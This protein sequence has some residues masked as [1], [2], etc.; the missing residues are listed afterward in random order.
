MSCCSVERRARII[1]GRCVLQRCDAS[2]DDVINSAFFLTRLLTFVSRLCGGDAIDA[3]VA[4]LAGL[5]LVNAC[6]QTLASRST[7]CTASHEPCAT[8]RSAC[9]KTRL[10]ANSAVPSVSV[11]VAVCVVLLVICIARYV[12][13]HH[14]CAKIVAVACCVARTRIVFDGRRFAQDDDD[15]GMF[16]PLLRRMHH[17]LR[18]T[19]VR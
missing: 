7:T 1:D 19:R 11:R 2:R 9:Q 14:V 18:A 15:H 12:P 16:A 5:L 10:L 4:L 17:E 13:P 8:R 3:R 6:V